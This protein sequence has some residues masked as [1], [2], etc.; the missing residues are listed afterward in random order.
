MKRANNRSKFLGELEEKMATLNQNY[1]KLAAGYL[2]PE[3]RKR[4]DAFKAANPDVEIFRLGVGDTTEP[5][6]KFIADFI[7]ESARRLA[8]REGYG[9]G[10]ILPEGHVMQVLQEAD[11]DRYTGY[12]DEQGNKALRAAM[13][14][15]YGSRGIAIEPGEVFINDGAKTD[16]AN[17]G[18]IFSIDSIVAVEDPSYPVPVDSNVIAG[19]AGKFND[20]T[21]Q[22]ERIV[23]MPC[24]KENG[25]FPELPHGV[26]DLIYLIRPNNPTG[27]V[28]TK[29]QLKK[30]VDYA[31]E[32]KA[33]IIFDAAYC[34][35][36]SDP[37]LPKSI[38]EIEGAKECAI[39]INS[40]SKWAGFTGIR[41][42][43]TVVPKRMI[44]DED[45]PGKT[46]RLWNRR[47]TT[48]FNGAS[49]L[50]QAGMLGVLTEEGQ[51]ECQL[52]INFYKKNAQII[53]KGLQQIGFEVFGGDNSPF[54]WA[55]TPNSMD[56]WEFFDKLIRETHV[57]CTPGAGFG[58]S[59]RGYVRFS[60]FGKRETVENAVESVQ[61][62]LRL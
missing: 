25:F 45:E 33:V 44:S 27:A 30:F 56:S 61:K 35:F 37:S 59:G 23:Y 8:F 34:S 12:G 51:R 9:K 15:D 6:P 7:E 11:Y 54:V 22:Y 42:G 62:N 60:A 57:V 4:V 21:K 48:M 20:K 38:Y 47:Q 18:S 1:D 31:R 32:H 53:K 50:A 3:I 43:W 16:S 19:R 36:I 14:K 17:I 29:E 10:R 5:L 46:N 52:V 49:L 13:A 28:A 24:T 55:Q 2:F 39:E 41:G 58:P 26:V 40:F